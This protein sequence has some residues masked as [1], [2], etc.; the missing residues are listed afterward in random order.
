[1]RLFS[2]AL[3]SHIMLLLL[4]FDHFEIF[5]TDAAFWARPII[6]YV[7]PASA[8]RNAVVRQT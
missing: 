7:V 8:C 2:E 6:G 5:F 4:D 3:L 1:M